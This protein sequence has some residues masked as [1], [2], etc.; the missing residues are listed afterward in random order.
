MGYKEIKILVSSPNDALHERKLLLDYLPTK[1]W[2]DG[3]ED[4]CNSRIL[5]KGWEDIPSQV[6]HPQD[7]INSY[8]VNHVDIVLVVFKFKIG[9]PLYND[10]KELRSESGTVEELNIALKNNECG[11]K[12]LLIV[13]FYENEP[14]FKILS[15]FK[16]CIQIREWKKLLHFKE[17]IQSKILYGLFNDNEDKFL[18]LVCRDVCEH[19]I[20]H[21]IL[22]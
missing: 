9:T 15:I 18:K 5:C 14:P 12:P 22:K 2:R 13:Y 11:R 6:G 4:R 7:L 21:P 16:Y 1:F 8:L 10:K 20:N 19:V 3:F 17:R